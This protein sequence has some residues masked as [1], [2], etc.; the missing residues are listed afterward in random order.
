MFLLD[1]E[2]EGNGLS[3]YKILVGDVQS[4]GVDNIFTAWEGFSKRVYQ[5]DLNFLFSHR[6]SGSFGRQSQ[7]DIWF[8]TRHPSSEQMWGTSYPYYSNGLKKETGRDQ[9]CRMVKTLQ[10]ILAVINAQHN[11]A[12]Y[13]CVAGL[14][15]DYMMVLCARCK[16][17]FYSH[18]VFNLQKTK[19]HRNHAHPPSSKSI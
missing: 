5:R 8:K 19:A 11:K 3:I 1:I 14:L 6:M 15:L 18:A 13:D 4:L 12:L 9:C 17:T 10:S 7:H 16:S 2:P